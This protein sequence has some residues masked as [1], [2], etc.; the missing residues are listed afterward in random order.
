MNGPGHVP[1][2]AKHCISKRPFLLTL[3]QVSRTNCIETITRSLSSSESDESDESEASPSFN[4]LLLD[5]AG[6]VDGLINEKW[7]A[8]WLLWLDGL[9]KRRLPRR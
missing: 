2:L 3:V 4:K 5:S 1:S 9:R 7:V 6:V 8:C